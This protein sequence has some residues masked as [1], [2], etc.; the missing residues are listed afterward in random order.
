MKKVQKING[1]DV[2]YFVDSENKVV[3]ALIRDC[4]RDVVDRLYSDF[5]LIMA[6]NKKAHQRLYLPNVIKTIATCHPDDCFDVEIG[7]KIA[8][9]R[10]RKRYWEKYSD[11]MGNCYGLLGSAI[12]HIA[13]EINSANDISFKINPSDCL[14]ES[15]P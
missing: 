1:H 3:G 4:S 13:D 12:S 6:S 9:K 7:M 10:L 8:E 5:G 2:S 14:N 11:R 15:M